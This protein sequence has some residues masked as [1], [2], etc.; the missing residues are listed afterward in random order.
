MV[1]AERSHDEG[2]FAAVFLRPF[3]VGADEK[4]CVFDK[5]KLTLEEK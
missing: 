1:T 2:C 5:Q 4:E 3:S